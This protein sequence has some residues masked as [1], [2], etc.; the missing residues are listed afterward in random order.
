VVH[1]ALIG[2]VDLQ[3]DGLGERDS[4]PPLMPTNRCPSSSNSTV[5]TVPAG[6]GEFSG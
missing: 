2:A 6:P 3:R 5:I 1:L 4:G